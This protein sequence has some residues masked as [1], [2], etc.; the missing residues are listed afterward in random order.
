VKKISQVVYYFLVA[1][2]VIGV[3]CGLRYRWPVMGEFQQ[4]VASIARL[5]QEEK[6]VLFQGQIYKV[7]VRLK[8]TP[9]NT[10]VL[11]LIPDINH[12]ARAVY[13]LYPRRITAVASP[14]LALKALHEQ[15]FDYVIIYTVTRTNSGLV[16]MGQL[17][18][19]WKADDFLS[20][21]RE[22]RQDDT[23]SQDEMAQ[24]LNQNNGIL[25]YKFIDEGNTE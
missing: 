6:N 22:V 8:Q 19:Y 2:I 9:K 5:S 20:F 18:Q 10:R 23:L 3:Y 16:P 11:Y 7:Y 13:F 12:L 24:E 25:L 21:L 17:M 15:K 4:Q 1:W 14:T